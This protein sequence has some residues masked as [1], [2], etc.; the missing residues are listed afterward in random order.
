[1][2]LFTACGNDNSKMTELGPD[3]T[4]NEKAKSATSDIVANKFIDKVLEDKITD[5]LMTIPFVKKTNQYLDS[6]TG[7]KHGIVFTVDSVG[8]NEIFVMAGYNGP[9]KFET[10][11]RF[12]IHPET[13]DIM[14]EYPET[15]E[16]ISIDQYIKLKKD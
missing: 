2:F 6:L 7:H 15:G 16:L 1:L 5:T 13:F 9:E 12:T 8:N 14:I 10:Y 11:F 3:P 4:V